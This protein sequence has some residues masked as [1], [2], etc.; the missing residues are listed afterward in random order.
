MTKNNKGTCNI[1][2]LAQLPSLTDRRLKYYM[3]GY[4]DKNDKQSIHKYLRDLGL[5][6]DYSIVMVIPKTVHAC[7]MVTQY[8]LVAY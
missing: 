8:Q 4:V 2:M 1:V 7:Q 6:I 3:Y 5:F